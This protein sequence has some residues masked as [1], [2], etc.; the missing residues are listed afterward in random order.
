LSSYTPAT[1]FAAKDSLAAGNPNKIVKGTEIGAEFTAI[2][3]AIATKADSTSVTVPASFKNKV[4][5]PKMDIAQRG[6]SFPGLGASTGTYTLDGW[7]WVAANTG[8]VVNVSQQADVAANSEC[9]NSL[10][11]TVT[12][13]DAAVTATK[14]AVIRQPIEGFLVRDL[15]GNPIAV[16]F[17]DK[18]PKAGIHCVAI[19]NGAQ[20]RSYVAEYTLTAANTW[21]TVTIPLS[22]TGLPSS[23]TWNFT[24]G[25]GL[26]LVKPLM[27]GSNFQT[28]PGAW[29]NGNFV[30]TSN[31]QNLLDTLSNVCA[32][33]G[34]QLEKAAASTSLEHRDPASETLLDQRYFQQGIVAYLAGV[35]GSSTTVGMRVMFPTMRSSP[36]LSGIA[37]NSV[38]AIGS[39]TFSAVAPNAALVS[40]LGTGSAGFILDT[41][42]SVSAE[43]S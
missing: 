1:N 19:Q 30:A 36:T 8:A 27:A 41:S 31:Q 34:V 15:L 43:L 33:T 13:A 32:I 4:R 22:A 35:S 28:T 7:Q 20:D 23:G 3:T 24:T 2:A 16:R 29:Q 17:E 39:R 10:R 40:A 37:D 14:L 26:Y 25:T 12:T 5:N 18:S 11:V 38:G 6:T 9:Q 42:F 21:Q